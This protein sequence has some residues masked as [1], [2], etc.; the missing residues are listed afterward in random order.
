MKNF[1]FLLKAFFV[2][3]IWVGLGYTCLAQE[4]KLVSGRVTNKSDGNKPVTDVQIYAY[5]T[6]A[7]A[8]DAYE[9]LMEARRTGGF[10]SAGLVT[11]TF[12]DTGGYYEVS[13]SPT[14]ALL[15]YTGLVDPILE[16]VNYRLEINVQFALEIV[17]DA[18][19]KKADRIADVIILEP[20]TET[21]ENIISPRAFPFTPSERLLRPDSRLVIQSMVVDCDT[22]D[23]VRF[24]QPTVLDAE[25]YHLT[26]LRRMN[27]DG[28]IDPLYGIASSHPP[29]TDSL[30]VVQWTDTI[31]RETTDHFYQCENNI[32]LEDYNHVYY[33]FSKTYDTKRLRRPMQF[34][35]YSFDRY[36]LDP[37]K[38][39]KHPRR[40][41]R[42]AA[43]NISLTFLVG[44]AQLDPADTMNIYYLE[45]LKNELRGI[46]TGEGSTLKEFHI[47]GVASPD[48]QY[49]R[50][51][52]LAGRRMAFALDQIASVLPQRVRDR[53]YMTRKS[54]VA[55]WNEVAD[56]LFSDSLKQEA[57]KVREIVERYPGNMDQQWSRIRALPFYKSEITPRLPKLR[58]V[59][60]TYVSEIYRE[61]TPLEILYRYDNDDDYRSG[62]KDFALYEYWHLFNLVKDEGEL[63][64]LYRRAISA[65]EKT[66][67]KPWVLPANNLAV[68]CLDRDI[69]DTTIL[70]PFI[71]EDYPCNY[72]IR[73]MNRG[74]VEILNPE[75]VIANQVVTFLMLKKYSRAVQLS[76]YLP[77]RYGLLKAVA[78]CLAGYFRNADTEEGRKIFSVVRDSS[79]RNKV[80]MNLAVG[81][82]G[83]ARS[84]LAALPQDDPVTMYLTAQII[85]R[86]NTDALTMD[87]EDYDKALMSLAD[88]FQSDRKFIRTAEADWDI[89]EDILKDAKAE[90]EMRTSSGN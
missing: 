6:V 77:D 68:L 53:V 82:I 47:E 57:A 13:V 70:A 18:A 71:N 54:R 4:K 37:E 23:T 75:Q 29:L 9:Q 43:G 33:R 62:R 46:I 24:C 25:Q 67:G 81:N 12:P 3:L 65:S 14:G 48:G 83:L 89:F 38:F 10:F 30:T 28:Y 8:Q 17:L 61:L 22:G 90:Y 86:S 52:E 2:L 60:Y 7:E 39:R 64:K 42:D 40:E 78:K 58:S 20:P 31:Y 49:A 87:Y 16:K 26:Q 34:L 41:R 88:C 85:C 21:G 76:A 27:F 36:A 63:E 44:K 51:V 11:E 66:E 35:E 74:T 5:N 55:S 79:P 73:D 15:F 84:A 59:S 45:S 69:A 32:W 72:T 1:L 80:V 19:T 50:N 56:L